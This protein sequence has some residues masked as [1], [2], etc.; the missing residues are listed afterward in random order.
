MWI[1][2]FHGRQRK[3]TKDSNKIL[4]TNSVTYKSYVC[5]MKYEAEISLLILLLK[6]LGV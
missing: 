6:I 5:A 4:K 1:I 2:R 3:T